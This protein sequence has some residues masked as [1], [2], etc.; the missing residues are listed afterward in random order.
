[1]SRFSPG[2]ERRY[3]FGVNTASE[4]ELVQINGIQHSF[5]GRTRSNQRYSTQL[6]R[7]N[8]SKSTVFHTASEVELIQI[9][10]IPHSFRGRTH[11]N[12]R[13]STQLQRQNS[14]KSTVFNTASE[15]ELVQ[16]NGIPHSFRQREGRHDG[17]H[18]TLIVRLCFLL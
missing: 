15:A 4:A 16:I 7:Q 14:S 13:Y 1:M 18:Q 11:S 6:Q 10:G 3:C 17:A 5:R 12:Q 8:S 2:L 9:N